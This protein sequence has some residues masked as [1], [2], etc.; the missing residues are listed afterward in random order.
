TNIVTPLTSV[1]TNVA[2]DHQQ[3]LG[4]TL[5]QIASE[6]AGIIKPGVP[7][8]T[9]TDGLEALQVIEETARRLHAPFVKVCSS[10]FRVPS[11]ELNSELRMPLLGDH[12]R[13]NAA[14][15]AATV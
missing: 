4:D 11:S 15:A 5:A 3:W 2:L 10:E 13:I 7:V 12:Q 9:A 14:L 6:K 8:I 1:I